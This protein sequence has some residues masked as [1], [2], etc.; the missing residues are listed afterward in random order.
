MVHSALGP[1]T[2]RHP[3]S[4]QRP[5]A[6]HPEHPRRLAIGGLPS[7]VLLRRAG[8]PRLPPLSHVVLVFIGGCAGALARVG[9]ATAFPTLPG[10]LPL[11]TLLENVTGAFLLALLLSA[12][13]SRVAVRPSVRLAL[14]TGVLGSF[15]T[16]S[17]LAV[18]VERLLRSGEAPLGLGYA[19]LT[20]VLGLLAAGLGLLTGRAL[21]HRAPQRR[22]DGGAS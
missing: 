13:G 12:A 2:S 15:T 11:T 4:D 6:T 21:A 5:A 14:G 19:A 7:R 8:G 17:T 3:P 10:S 22:A 16:Y 1:A 18:E 20:L 9:L